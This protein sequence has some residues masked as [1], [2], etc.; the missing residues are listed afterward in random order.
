MSEI[1]YLIKKATKSIQRYGLFDFCNKKRSPLRTPQA[2]D[3][4]KN[5]GF[6]SS[7]F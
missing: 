3:Y 2:V 6:V 5:I 1:H 7:L 4:L